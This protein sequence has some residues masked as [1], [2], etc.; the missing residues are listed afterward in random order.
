MGQAASL[1][2]VSSPV[3]G[4]VPISEEEDNSA[5]QILLSLR[6]VNPQAQY[7]GGNS[8]LDIG[9]GGNDGVSENLVR[10]LDSV[11]NRGVLV[12]VHRPLDGLEDGGVVKRPR[13]YNMS[14]LQKRKKKLNRHR[15]WKQK[16]SATYRAAVDEIRDHSLQLPQV[17]EIV[18]S[19]STPGTR[20][21]QRGSK[22]PR[23]GGPWRIQEFSSEIERGVTGALPLFE[24]VLQQI[25]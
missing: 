9:R 11:D 23:R 20:R 16:N 12:P 3:T 13:V 2:R 21:A 22:P 7:S 6:H 8:S 18:A 10:P 4:E 15:G 24:W 1:D 14:H 5:S 25:W 19:I 17:R